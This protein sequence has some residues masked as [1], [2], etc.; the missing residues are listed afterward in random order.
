[1][2]KS[3]TTFPHDGAA[4]VFRV[5]HR[6]HPLYQQEFELVD[7]RL[8]WGEDRVYYYDEEDHLKSL[9]A[10]YTNVQEEDPY[11]MIGKGRAYFRIEDLLELARLL[12]EESDG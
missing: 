1:L 4:Q 8:N 7:R 11:I 3:S 2:T 6:F 12:R 10:S 5:V 9:P